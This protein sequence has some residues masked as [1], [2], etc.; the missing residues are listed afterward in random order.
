MLGG[1]ILTH[2]DEDCLARMAASVNSDDEREQRSGR[3]A[4]SDDPDDE[5]GTPIAV[6]PSTIAACKKA[7]VLSLSL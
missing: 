2:P 1:A 4:E 5:T 3:A 6:N 7:H